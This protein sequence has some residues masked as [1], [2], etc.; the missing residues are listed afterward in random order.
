MKRM[1]LLLGC[2]FVLFILSCGNKLPDNDDEG[3]YIV[4]DELDES[5]SVPVDV[6]LRIHLSDY[7][8]ATW[9]VD[10][11]LI[12]NFYY[13][14]YGDTKILIT[15]SPGTVTIT[16]TDRDGAV[17]SCKIQVIEVEF[18]IDNLKP[19]NL[20]PI[21]E[22]LTIRL[23]GQLSATWTVDD[24]SVATFS[25]EFG[26]AT[27]LTANS[28]GT[29]TITA[30]TIYK[31]SYSYTINVVGI[32]IEGLIDN[33]FVPIGEKLTVRLS[34]SSSANWKTSDASV[35]LLSQE[36]GKSTT[37]TIKKY[38]KEKVIISA[39]DENGKIYKYDISTIN[40]TFL[41]Q[42]DY[43]VIVYRDALNENIVTE[44]L[45]SETWSGY[46]SPNNKEISF[47]FKYCI[48]VVDDDDYG[49]VWL[50]VEHNNLYTYFIDS[51]DLENHYTEIS[52]SP[53]KYLQFTDAYLKI[54]NDS[55]GQCSL[56]VGNNQQQKTIR[57]TL[58][59]Q[60]NKTGIYKIPVSSNGKKFSEWE[61]K[62][63]NQ[64]ISI[65]EFTVQNGGIY[66]CTFDGESIK[67]K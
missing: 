7:S 3:I 57:D 67:S 42:S 35:A 63:S 11:S 31:K 18:I 59:I 14:Y 40:I 30:M 4:I 58:Y 65:T 1:T 10:K 39:E 9:N 17:H 24:T 53:P 48:Q 32:V 54:F 21:N 16:A 8:N 12:A 5:K 13:S 50:N 23:N 2:V 36:T 64:N 34:N 22:S 66:E 62:T 6:E 51:V 43:K 61:F 19:R 41:N 49:R 44:L 20:I 29:V 46:V 60:P 52:I 33:Q 47:Y 55:N 28:L 26:N 38:S 56:T 15:K 27:K 37:L 45:S 25:Q